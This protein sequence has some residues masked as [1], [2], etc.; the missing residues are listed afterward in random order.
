[1]ENTYKK[2]KNRPEQPFDFEGFDVCCTVDVVG[3]IVGDSYM[4]GSELLPDGS[5]SFGIKNKPR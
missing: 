3:P 4:Y 2:Q 5:R 1:M